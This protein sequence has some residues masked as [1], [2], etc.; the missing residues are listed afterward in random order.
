MLSLG[1][2]PT[3]EEIC[4]ASKVSLK[5]LR[6]APSRAGGR[7]PRSRSATTTALLDDLIGVAGGV[8]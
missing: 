7:A 5:H 2:T 6:E 1:R 3:D 8:I 4:K